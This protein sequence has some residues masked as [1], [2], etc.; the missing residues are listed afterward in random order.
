MDG[1][2]KRMR[3]T[4]ESIPVHK[5]LIRESLLPELALVPSHR[6]ATEKMTGHLASRAKTAVY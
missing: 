6:T 3:A 5:A 1:D 2:A 4:K